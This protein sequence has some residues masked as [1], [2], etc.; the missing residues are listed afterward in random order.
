[1]EFNPGTTDSHRVVALFFDDGSWTTARFNGEAWATEDGGGL[2]AKR[3]LIPGWLEMA[4]A[5]ELAKRRRA[6]WEA[7]R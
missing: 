4:E 5:V 7:M 3:C 1:M 2:G 6:E